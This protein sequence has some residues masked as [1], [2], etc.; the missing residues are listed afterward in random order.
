MATAGRAVVFSGT[1]VAIGLALLLLVPVP[2]VRSLGVGGF[3]V[4]LASI[5]AAATLQPALLSLAGRR[6]AR[7]VPVAAFLRSR[8]GIR[9]PVLPGTIDLESGFWARLARAIMRRP[10][11]FL[12][13]GTA[14]LLALAA[15]AF[16]LHVTPGSV[17]ALPQF[18]ESVRG[19]TLLRSGAGAGALTPTE[20]VVDAGAAGRARSRTVHAAI[21]RLGDELFRDPEV[22]VVALGRA[23]PYVA[24]GGRYARVIVVGR[25]EY[26]DEATQAFVRRLRSTLVPAARFPAGVRV[27][28]G[29]GPPQGVDYLSRSYGAFPW[30][31][32]GVL[33][34]TYLVLLRAFRSL[35]L[36]LKAVVLNVLT[37]AAVYGMLVVIF[38]WGVGAHV[39]GLYRVPQIEGWIPIFLFAVLFGLSMDYEV[40]LVSRMRESWDHVHD[41]GRAVA[42]GLERTGRIITAAALIMVVAFSG[43]VAGRVAGLQEFGVGLSLA[44]L[45]DATLV[46]M[47][48]VPS[49]MA[50]LDR[51]NWWLPA[52]IARLAR[53]QASTLVEEGR[54]GRPSS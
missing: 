51:R 25:H 23:S 15:P 10:V 38:R 14:I 54:A 2:F 39:L 20:I 22:S 46:R 17:S 11:A 16:Y 53:V 28:A 52:R 4:P 47:I 30:L 26:G 8:L 33:V 37:V 12:A 1:T 24:P 48:L 5:V 9:L 6:G 21:E 27:V 45:L 35:V 7:R 31:V 32:L 44:V 43:F 40:F 41:N 29:G 50:V 42:H 13:V 19:L 3:V 49:F 18:P 34:L 36:P